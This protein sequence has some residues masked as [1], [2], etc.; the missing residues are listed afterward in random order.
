LTVQS[1]TGATVGTVSQVV[2]D[3]SGNV[4]LVIVTSPTGQTLRLSPTTLT[5]SGNTVITTGM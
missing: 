3:R 1:S 2:T 4:R 5:M